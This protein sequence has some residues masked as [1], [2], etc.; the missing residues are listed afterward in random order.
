M[1]SSVIGAALSRMTNW[2][3]RILPTHLPFSPN[4][5]PL[6]MLLSLL[7]PLLLAPSNDGAF[8]AMGGTLQPMQET[9]VEMRREVLTLT[10]D[11]DSM[12]VTVD[13][14]FYNPGPGKDLTVG[15]V[16]PP[17]M[18]DVGED[19]PGYRDF[20]VQIDGEAVPFQTAW[21]EETG[22]RTPGTEVAGIDYVYYFPV[23]FAPGET[24]IQHQYR[25]RGSSFVD[26]EV[27]FAYRLTTAKGW[28]GGKIGDFT[29]NLDLG[30]VT[31]ALLT[32]RFEADARADWQVQGRGYLESA[33]RYFYDTPYQRLRTSQGR[34]Q[35][36]AQDFSPDYD[37]SVII[38]YDTDRYPDIPFGP[39]GSLLP[40][41]PFEADTLESE[42][43]RLEQ[44]DAD[45]TRYSADELRILRNWLFARHGYVFRDPYL[46]ALFRRWP[47]YRPDP[48]VQASVDSLTPAE[49]VLLKRV[50]GQEARAK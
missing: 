23:R 12:D 19:R 21:L 45:L 15:F 49:Q 31:Y 5:P 27:S 36:K 33:K 48:S 40:G 29:L 39:I 28:A 17:A 14:T 25:F 13:F 50:K 7:F 35:L 4:P 34:L 20:R 43:F 1:S 26:Y 16:T 11:G 18:G 38:P 8:Y 42:L 44:S 9:Q 6:N 32:E 2:E 10:R 30:P 37:F 24:R 22:F 47:G 41:R 46:D 3:S